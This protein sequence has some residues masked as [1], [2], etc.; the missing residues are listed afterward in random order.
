MYQEKYD[1]MTN[2]IT[3]IIVIIVFLLLIIFKIIPDLKAI[4]GSSDTYIN[5]D[6]YDTVVGIKINTNT[7]FLLVIT[8]NKVQNIIFLSSNSLFLYN[9]NIEGNTISNSL[10][11]VV[12]ILRNN[13][14][15]LNELTLI[16]Y[17]K[18]S[19][20]NDVKQILANNLTLQE[21][22]S[23]YQ[24]LAVEYNIKS[25]QDNT[26][27]LQ[28]IEAYSK[29]ITRKYKNDKIL[30]ETLKKQTKEELQKAANN[31]Y[32]KLEK[33]A[34]NVENQ[35]IYSTS[36]IITDIPAN[37]DLTLY[38]SVD[39]W[40]YIKNHQVYAYINFKTTSNNYDFCYNGS[41]YNMKEGKCS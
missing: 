35:E 9:K 4:R 31:V 5:Y 11:N 28:A 17:P 14:V 34:K 26:E 7:D 38:P 2:I 20:Y 27:Q 32:S 23:T 1:K 25:Y 40:Y 39:S 29:E 10:T 19:S 36:L 3:I 12:N 8:D 37:Q 13:D 33:Y 16:K 18:N 30:K 22:E 24:L 41:I 15:L 21:K 6:K